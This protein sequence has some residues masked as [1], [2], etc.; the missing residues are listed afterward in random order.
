MLCHI[1][2]EIV[3]NPWDEDY[4]NMDNFDTF[5]ECVDCVDMEE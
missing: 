1:T 3:F 4:I 5:S 2:D